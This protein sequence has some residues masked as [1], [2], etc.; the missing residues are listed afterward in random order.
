M[1][2]INPSKSATVI[3]TCKCG[4]TIARD[5]SIKVKWKFCILFKHMQFINTHNFYSPETGSKARIK[6]LQY[7]EQNLTKLRILTQ[8]NKHYRYIFCTIGIAGYLRGHISR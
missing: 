7:M 6:Y 5:K 3:F 4:L 2:I 8:Y 1:Y